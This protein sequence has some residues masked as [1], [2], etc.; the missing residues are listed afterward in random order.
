[1]VGPSGIGKDVAIRSAT[2]LIDEISPDLDVGGKTM[3][4]IVEQI[5]PRD[6]AC[7]VIAA[8]EITAFLGGKDYQKSM[9][10]ELTDLLTTGD[11]INVSLKSHFGM[12]RIINQPTITMLAGSTE[13]WLHKAMPDG[14]LEGGLFPRFLIVCEEYGSKHIPLI[15][16]S[17]SKIERD[18]A[19]EKKHNFIANVSAI[20]TTLND[21][22]HGTEIVPLQEAIEFYENWYINRFRYFGPTVRAYANRSRDQVLRLAMLTAVSCERNYINLQDMTFARDVINYVGAKIE[23]AALP[24]SRDAQVAKAITAILPATMK[25][26]NN[27]LSRKYTLKEI[28]AGLQLLIESG[29]TT[30]EGGYLLRKE[31]PEAD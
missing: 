24:P 5:L 25:Q 12:K 19:I 27:T 2:R 31:D 8:P 9:V 6:P 17:I 3:E 1:L 10:Q 30:T 13:E 26:I 4:V 11:K 22:R 15:K 14:S 20:V 7:A 18:Q 29:R 28:Q 16:H 21:R 23:Q